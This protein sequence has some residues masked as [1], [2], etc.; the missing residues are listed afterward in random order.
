MIAS[1]VSVLVVL[2]GILLPDI[3]PT[4]S[5]FEFQI[6]S[7]RFVDL[8][9]LGEIRDA[10][11]HYRPAVQSVAGTQTHRSVEAALRVLPAERSEWSTA[12]RSRTARR[13]NLDR[14]RKDR[15]SQ[16]AHRHHANRATSTD[17]SI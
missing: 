4:D 13:T 7:V 12:S 8:G 14:E 11:R 3:S 9:S 5:S 15:G 2:N 6:P 16:E 10:L 1:V 17:K